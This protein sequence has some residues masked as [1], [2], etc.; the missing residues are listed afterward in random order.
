MKM[1][2]LVEVT[3]DYFRYEDLVFVTN[4]K[5]ELEEFISN[6]KFYNSEIVRKYKIEDK[7][8]IPEDKKEQ[9]HLWI[10]EREVKHD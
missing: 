9:S 1:Y 4:N 8:N 2:C 5:K 6:S 7:L 3:Y 10:Y